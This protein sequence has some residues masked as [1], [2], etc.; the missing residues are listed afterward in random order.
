MISEKAQRT[1]VTMPN[2]NYVKRQFISALR[3]EKLILESKHMELNQALNAKCCDN[4]KKSS[5]KP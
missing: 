5:P 1:T 3:E 4:D 2:I